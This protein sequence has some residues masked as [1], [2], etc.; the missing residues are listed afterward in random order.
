MAP[1][2]KRLIAAFG[3]NRLGGQT[4]LVFGLKIW[5][6]A[7]SFAL[8]WLI[9]RAFGAAGSGHFGIAVTTITILSHVVLS[10]LDYTVVRVVA[11]DLREGKQAQA[12]GVVLA[13]VRFVGIAAPSLAL[14]LWLAREPLAVHVLHQPGMPGLLG[15][16]LW[17][18]VPFGLQRIA[19]AA[20]RGTGNILA[21]QVID[22]PSGTT[23]AAAGLAAALFAGHTGSLNV[24]GWLYLTGYS[25]SAAA[26]LLI[27]RRSVRSWPRAVIPAALPLAAAGVP[28]L[29]SNLSNMFTEWYTTVSLGSAWPAAVVGQYRVA[30]QFVAIA[31]LMQVAMDTILGPRIAAAAR[32]GDKAAIA[33]TARRS[34]ALVTVLA[35]PLFA[36]FLLFPETLLSLFGPQFIGGAMA[37]RILA[38]GQLARL[39]GGPLGTV[40]VMTGNQRWVLV[41]S[42]AGVIPCI[43]FVALLV[44]AYGAVGAAA[45]TAAA[46]LLRNGTAIIVAQRVLGINL[47][48]PSRR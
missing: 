3:K 42:A 28:I 5:S 21:S 25:V 14:L 45:A 16:M 32:V 34:I 10:G 11:G 47:F 33:R 40:L 30:W 4:V 1:S 2:P 26:G 17:T 13:A 41:Y 20:L 18:L 46:V 36:A 35:S 22:G 15:I 7:A 27:Y 43:I 38:L 48:F 31:G 8:S 39:M 6:A 29:L 19:S 12:K 24:P 37:L 9:A 23:I 44:P